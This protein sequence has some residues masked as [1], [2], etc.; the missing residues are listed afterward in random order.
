MLPYGAAYDTEAVYQ[1]A[2]SPDLW[3]RKM[4]FGT[5]CTKR[6]KRSL[7]Y[8]KQPQ[9]IKT[10]RLR[11]IPEDTA[12]RRVLCVSFCAFNYGISRMS[13]TTYSEWVPVFMGTPQPEMPEETT[14]RVPSLSSVP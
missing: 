13:M 8:S 1:S 9:N 5:G 14:K 11:R 3:Q 7:S 6:F 10:R 2:S 12:A 4:R